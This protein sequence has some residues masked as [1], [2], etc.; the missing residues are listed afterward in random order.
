MSKLLHFERGV[1]IRS[2]LTLLSAV[3]VAVAL[4]C[5]HSV[6]SLSDLKRWEKLPY[7]G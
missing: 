2:S 4:H 1:S 7:K 5:G 6:Q 3:F